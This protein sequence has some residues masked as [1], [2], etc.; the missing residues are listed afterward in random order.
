MKDRESWQEYYARTDMEM[1]C[2]QA[3]SDATARLVYDLIV[4]DV[5][6][7]GAK[8]ALTF[9]EGLPAGM[10]AEQLQRLAAAYAHVVLS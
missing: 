7:F 10:D 5:C 6:I 3:V 9:P 2:R 1:K 8:A 4:G